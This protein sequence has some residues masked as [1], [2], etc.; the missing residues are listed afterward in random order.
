MILSVAS[1]RRLVL[2]LSPTVKLLTAS[3]AVVMM[4]LTSVTTEPAGTVSSDLG[5]V[6]PQLKLVVLLA[7][8][9]N[10]KLPLPSVCK[11]CRLLPPVIL[12]L[13]TAMLLIVL[14]VSTL[15]VILPLAVRPAPSVKVMPMLAV[16][17]EVNVCCKFSVG[18][19]GILAHKPL[20]DKN[21]CPLPL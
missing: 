16:L 14:T 21:V 7:T 2:P 5:L 4:I 9:A 20:P 11:N 10:D 3:N 6:S 13:A 17:P 12:T 1:I 8:L 18:C 15:P 19:T